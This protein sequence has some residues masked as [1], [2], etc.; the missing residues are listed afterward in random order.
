MAK[1]RS[2]NQ[3]LEELSKSKLRTLL[4]DWIVNELSN[5]F[6]IDFEVRLCSSMDSDIQEVSKSSFYIQLKSSLL[7]E[8]FHDLDIDDW[9]LFVSQELPVVLIKYCE[10][11]DIFYWEIIQTYVWDI[12]ERSDPNWKMRKSKRLKFKNKLENLETIKY[13]ILDAQKR[14]VRHS[15]LSLGLGEGINLKDINERETHKQ[16]SISE[17]KHISFIEASTYYQ[18]GNRSKA[19]TSLESIYELPYEDNYKLE[20]IINWIFQMNF[21]N[22]ELNEKIMELSD[23][24][25]G[26]SRRNGVFNFEHI[27][28]ILK[29]QAKLAQIII[30]MSQLMLLKKVQTIIGVDNF[31]S[32]PDQ[33]MVNEIKNSL[34]ELLKNESGDIFSSISSNE[35]IELI[36]M[37]QKVVNEINNSLEELLK[38][39]YPNDYILCLSIIVEVIT[40]QIQRFAPIDLEV[41]KEEASGRFSLILQCEYIVKNIKNCDLKQLMYVKLSS[42]YYWTCEQEKAVDCMNKAL[43]IVKEKG[44]ISLIEDYTSIL[45]QRTEKPDPYSVQMNH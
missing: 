10:K 9:T 43:E 30:R 18:E 31:S 28:I 25:I 26:L 37:H 45:N 42:Y 29:N 21:A 38:N 4:S 6:G 2:K 5:D 16:R 22:P 24:G 12:L 27:L 23:E 8:D 44:N 39:S 13:N 34:K 19:I 3:K 20:A 32:H 7:I 17:F 35:L 41:I 15:I 33:Q 1:K 36:Q 40:F 14:I 11:T